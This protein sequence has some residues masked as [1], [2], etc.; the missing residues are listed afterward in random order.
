MGKQ[1][2]IPGKKQIQAIRHALDE[3][4]AEFGAR[5]QRSARTVEDWEFG[6]RHPDRLVAS[7]M[8]ALAASVKLHGRKG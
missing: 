8:W 4:T 6:R 3:N 1:V 2:P 7:M 5:F